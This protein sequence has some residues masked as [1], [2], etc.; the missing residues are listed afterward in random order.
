[1]AGFYGKPEG[2]CKEDGERHQLPWTYDEILGKRVANVLRKVGCIV[3]MFRGF[4][5]GNI[6]FK[7]PIRLSIG[8]ALT[9]KEKSDRRCMLEILI[10]QFIQFDIFFCIFLTFFVKYSCKNIQ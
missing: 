2:T 6:L 10:S 5:M 4:F 3:P 8:I 1:M 7:C 9:C